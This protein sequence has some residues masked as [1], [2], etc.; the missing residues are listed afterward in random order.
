MQT[1]T[2]IT[3]TWAADHWTWS[4]A[5][6][7]FA[8][9]KLRIGCIMDRC[10]TDVR[11]ECCCWRF[12]WCRCRNWNGCAC[13][14][15]NWTRTCDHLW[16]CIVHNIV[17]YWMQKWRLKF[18]AQW[19][20]CGFLHR[21]FVVFE[22]I[23]VLRATTI[24]TWW[25]SQI[26]ATAIA[27]RA[28]VETI[29]IVLLEI[30]TRCRCQRYWWW[31]CRWRRRWSNRIVTRWHR[32]RFVITI[33]SDGRRWCRF[34]R[35]PPLF[36]TMDWIQKRRYCL[37]T[38]RDRMVLVR[39]RSIFLLIQFTSNWIR[40]TNLTFRSASPPNSCGYGRSNKSGLGVRTSYSSSRTN[41]LSRWPEQK[42]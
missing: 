1:I 40:I 39:F 17:E 14:W 9:T 4:V 38:K 12:C 7:L 23:F 15:P 11:T 35:W 26:T 6:T 13:E 22:H 28:V 41:G 36:E 42:I 25:Y 10:L 16:C 30:W 8:I 33:C 18:N 20:D 19:F 27:R 32:E 29:R 24:L 31:R 34:M 21:L 37:K 2:K 5:N 3:N